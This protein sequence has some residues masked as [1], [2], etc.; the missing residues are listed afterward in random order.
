M[1]LAEKLAYFRCFGLRNPFRVPV[2]DL[3]ECTRM[4]T[5]SLPS[6]KN[7]LAQGKVAKKTVLVFIFHS[8]QSG[9]ITLGEFCA[10]ENL[11]FDVKG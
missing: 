9:L 5:S 6:S 4:E 10:K 8:W 7:P 2:H 3:T 1:Q 11:P